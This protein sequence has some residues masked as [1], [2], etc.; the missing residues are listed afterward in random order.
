MLNVVGTA[1]PGWRVVAVDGDDIGEIETVDAQGVTVRKGWL[2]PTE[3]YVPAAA[4]SSADSTAEV[5]YLAVTKAQVEDDAYGSLEGLTLEGLTE[6]PAVAGVT[7]DTVGVTSASATSAGHV[8]V[9]PTPAP[10]ASTDAGQLGADG[11]ARIRT[12]EEELEGRAVAQQTGE[13]VV[14]KEIVED[15]QTV[16]VPVRREQVHVERQ[17]V[18]D[19]TA[20]PTAFQSA[21]EAIRV[22]VMEE[23]VEVRKVVRP[24]EEVV[25]SKEVVEGTQAVSG[26]V[27]REE[28]HVDED[29]ADL[30]NQQQ[31][32]LDQR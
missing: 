4:I 14:T 5:I 29:G 17:P 26:T 8:P 12:H 25:V 1:R 23:Q 28:V 15:T 3:R 18:T 11:S 32:G 16:Q 10:V 2:F 22:P 30:L 6:A 9:A 21:S 20:D 7:Q 31:Q 13:V 27:R 19:A 24:V